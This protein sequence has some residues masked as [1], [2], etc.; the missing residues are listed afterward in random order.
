MDDLWHDA[1]TNTEEEG[2]PRPVVCLPDN[3]R[4]SPAGEDDGPLVFYEVDDTANACEES[5]DG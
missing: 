3:G 5:P 4:V 1:W 2:N